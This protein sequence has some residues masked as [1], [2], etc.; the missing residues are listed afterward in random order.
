MFVSVVGPVALIAPPEPPAPPLP[1]APPFPPLPPELF[2][3]ALPSPPAAP[4]PATAGAHDRVGGAASR[5][6]VRDRNAVHGEHELRPHG[7]AGLTGPAGGER[8]R[9]RRGAVRER[10]ILD[11]GRAAGQHVDRAIDRVRIDRRR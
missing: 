7:A 3:P 11:P 8:A 5:V 10:E 2:A 4:A 6:A 1:P 9:G